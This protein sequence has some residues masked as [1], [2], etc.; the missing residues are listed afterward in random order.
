MHTIL[1]LGPTT[2][3]GY[4]RELL[5]EWGKRSVH[6][7]TC[8]TL[9]ATQQLAATGTDGPQ[10]AGVLAPDPLR[11]V[12]AIVV[13]Q[14]ELT[15]ED[16]RTHPGLTVVVLLNDQT[17]HVDIAAATAENIWVTRTENRSLFSRFR[18]NSDA[19]GKSARRHALQ[20]ALAGMS[21]ER[22]SGRVNEL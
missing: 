10:A 4:E 14:G 13:E 8:A 18:R 16:L 19:P 11:D 6:I 7:A 9:H 5:G 20:D 21:G 3:L 1:Y 12:S 2:D 17:A 22:P 15:T